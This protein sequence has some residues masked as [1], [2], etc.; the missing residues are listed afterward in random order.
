[1]SAEEW[2]K[3]TGAPSGACAACGLKLGPGAAYVAALLVREGAFVR[4]DRCEACAAAAA[5]SDDGALGVWRGKLAPPKGPLSRRLDFD[6]LIE[7]FPRLDGR[8]DEASARLRWV[9]ALLLLR[10]KFL[11]QHSRETRDGVELLT[12]KFR[13]DDRLFRVLD[14]R[15]DDAALAKLHEELGKIFDLDPTTKAAK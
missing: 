3:K 15:M 5:A 13:H 6:T 11:L 2:E 7:L 1:M 10:K 9:V 12:V 8:D 14:P 4:E